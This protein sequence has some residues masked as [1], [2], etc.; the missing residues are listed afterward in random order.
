MQSHYFNWDRLVLLDEEAKYFQVQEK[1]IHQV[2][3]IFL[4]RGRER[5]RERKKESTVTTYTHLS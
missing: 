2:G 3:F 5:E 1:E 4:E